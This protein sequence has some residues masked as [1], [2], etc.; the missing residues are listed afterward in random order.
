M[1]LQTYN[2]TRQMVSVF[3]TP[4][5]FEDAQRIAKALASS[6][7]VPQA[8]QGTAGIANCV[9]ALDLSRRTGASVMEI[10]QGLDVIHGKPR[11]SGKYCAAALRATGVNFDYEM[12]N[13]GQK[14]VQYDVWE[15]PKGSRTKRTLKET[16]Q[17]VACRIV[18]KDWKTG[19]WVSIEM[20]VKEGWYGKS[21]SKWQ[22]MPEMMLRYRAVSFFVNTEYPNILMGIPTE[23][24]TVDAPHV[25]VPSVSELLRQE[26]PVVPPQGG[27]APIQ[28]EIEEAELEDPELDGSEL[29]DDDELI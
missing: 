4:E 19:P 11:W 21:D 14:V 5:A 1:E 7:F 10:M 27:K 23:H 29:E 24:D 17:D 26:E 28:E 3:D 16:I 13:R 12:Q 18:T 6:S 22:T 2:P 8:Y 20:S 15:G 9:I 25:E